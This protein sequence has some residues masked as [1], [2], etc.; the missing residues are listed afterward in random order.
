MRFHQ[1]LQLALIAI[2]AFARQEQSADVLELRFDT[3]NEVLGAIAAD[4]LDAL[5]RDSGEDLRRLMETRLAP[6]ELSRLGLDGWTETHLEIAAQIPAFTQAVVVEDSMLRLEILTCLAAGLDTAPEALEWL[7]WTFSPDTEDPEKFRGVRVVNALAP[8]AWAPD[9]TRECA[10]DNPAQSIADRLLLETGSVMWAVG[11]ARIGEQPAN[12]V[13]AATAG[14]RKIGSSELA[15]VSDAIHVGSCTKSATALLMATL[16]A[17]GK[18]DWTDT[19]R[20]H[21]SKANDGA[22]AMH[23]AYADVTL[24]DVLRH[25]AGLAGHSEDIAAAIDR[26]SRL[27]GTPTE[28]RATYLADVLAAAPETTVGNTHYSNAGYCLIAHVCERVLDQ[29]YEQALQQRVFEPLGIGSAGFGWPATAANPGGVW[30]HGLDPETGLVTAFQEDLVLGAF[31]APA[32]DLQLD[33]KDFATLALQQVLG[34]R[35]DS[36]LAPAAVFAELQRTDN[37]SPYAC[38]VGPGQVDGH[39]YMGHVGSTGVHWAKFRAW[40]ELGLAAVVATNGPINEVQERH[41]DGAL[42]AIARQAAGE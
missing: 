41:V 1:Q 28:Q 16:V 15:Q 4:Y 12:T 37:G 38:G 23:A 40:P 42:R 14:A 34:P 2:V 25:R 6:R 17:E 27:E 32:G 5:Q 30:G 21:L 36:P 19:I 18:L 13:N 8:P 26:Y 20:S 10:A 3:R 24:A 11:I 33:I 31:L 9:Y 35:G 29:S 7:S 39:S 22:S